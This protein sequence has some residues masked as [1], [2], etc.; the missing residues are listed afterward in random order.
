MNFLQ[1]WQLVDWTTY[2]QQLK[3]K[4]RGTIIKVGIKAKG[5]EMIFLMSLT[6]PNDIFVF[7]FPMWLS[8][9]R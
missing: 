4:E 9:S 1:A 3:N 2:D 6:N 5:K 8:S 7:D